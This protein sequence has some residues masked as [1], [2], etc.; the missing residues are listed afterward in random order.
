[1]AHEPGNEV[2]S[3][4]RHYPWGRRIPPGMEISGLEALHLF[5]SGGYGPKGLPLW[6][7]E[8]SGS[9]FNILNRATVTQPE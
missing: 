1:M 5:S 7:Q 4:L 9:D 2:E 8:A 6:R 3:G